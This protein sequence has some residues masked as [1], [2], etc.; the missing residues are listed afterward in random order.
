MHEVNDSTQ[1]N[2]FEAESGSEQEN[3][4]FLTGALVRVDEVKRLGVV[5]ADDVLEVGAHVH[6]L[7]LA[8]GGNDAGTD[9]DAKHG[10]E[11]FTDAV[12]GAAAGGESGLAAVAEGG[13]DGDRAERA[14]GGGAVRGRG[15]LEGDTEEAV[16][17]F[18][19]EV[20]GGER[21][22]EE[23][24]GF[25]GETVVLDAEPDVAAAVAEDGSDDH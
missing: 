20:G 4:E 16:A 8:G 18:A 15:A 19:D 7:I 9:G 1:F 25:E 12:T 2:S 10:A 13:P 5:V 6:E 23:E 24:G 14:G 11:D 17:H 21:E 22:F 3:T